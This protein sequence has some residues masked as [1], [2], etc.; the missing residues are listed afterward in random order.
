[1]SIQQ[2][3]CRFHKKIKV[4]TDELR[5][6][7]DIIL[8]KIKESLKKAGHPL[9]DLINQ[10][11]YI[12]GVGVKPVGNVEYDIDVGLDFP[13][14]SFDYDAKTVRTW[15]FDAVDEHTNRVENKGPCIRIRYAAGY[16]VDL[17]VYARYKENNQNEE[18]QIAYKDDS[19]RPTAP[20]KLKEFIATARTRFA[21][22]KDSSGSDQLQR[23]TR[24]LKRWNDN[25]TPDDS[26]DKPIGLAT[27][28]LVIEQLKNPVVDT[29]GMPNDLEALRVVAEIA[30]YT[31][32]R[33]VIKKPTPEF[34]DVFGK[35]SDEAMIRFKKRLVSL[36]SDLE[37]AKDKND[38]DADKI[39]CGQFGDD[40]SSSQEK[41]LERMQEDVRVKQDIA[42]M[43]AA[44]PS[45]IKPSRP[46]CHV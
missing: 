21:K 40:F 6:K 42:D 3:F 41:N 25:N 17:V 36:L 9:P 28:L 33:V 31:F 29:D 8:D 1:M 5:E 11:S 24:Y 43:E 2:L 18:F 20:K 30:K 22:T 46:W 32:G 44:I 19:W 16:H 45:Y 37:S 39:L 10:G 12:Y 4:E 23:V 38:D 15:V 35:L 7:R 14:K 13:I 26:P 27:L 34:E